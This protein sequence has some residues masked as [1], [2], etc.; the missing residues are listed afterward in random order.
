MTPWNLEGATW[1]KS[2]FSQ[3]SNE[4]IETDG[5]RAIR[6]SKNPDGSILQ[7]GENGWSRFLAAV[8]AGSI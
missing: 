1:R 8:K 2:S 3:G 5:Q 7:F 4:C 6:D